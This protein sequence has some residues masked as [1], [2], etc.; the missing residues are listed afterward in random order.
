[1][2]PARVFRRRALIFP[3]SIAMTLN[4]L[5]FGFMAL[6][7]AAVGALLVA[8]PA[9]GDVGLPPYFWVLVAMLLFELAIFLRTGRN[10]GVT[11]TME[12]RLFG[13]VVGVVLMVAIPMIAGSPG[14]L[15]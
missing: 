1:M 3:Q 13:L 9:L 12:V 5:F 7:G 2:R 10:P 14:R 6:I 15:F 11:I 4:H 8:K